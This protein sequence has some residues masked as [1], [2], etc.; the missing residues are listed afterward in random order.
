MLGIGLRRRDWAPAAWVGKPVC[1]GRRA[2]ALG[3]PL[4][5]SKASQPEATDL[6]GLDLPH[7]R[8]LVLWGFFFHPCLAISK[9]LNL[10]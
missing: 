1:G 3:R 10:N 4:V 9:I 2:G 7:K 5:A 6:G 8:F